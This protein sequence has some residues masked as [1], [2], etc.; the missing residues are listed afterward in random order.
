MKRIAVVLGVILALVLACSAFF[1]KELV[2]YFTPIK[3]VAEVATPILWKVSKAGVPDSWLLGTMHAADRRS[4]LLLP[5]FEPYLQQ[6]RIVFTEHKLFSAEDQ[7]FRDFLFS[8]KGGV[9][10]ALG[11]LYPQLLSKINKA[12]L[13]ANVIE[14]MDV[15][16]ALMA[17][18]MR[19]PAADV[20]A[21]SLDEQ[22]ASFALLHNKAYAGLE[23]MQDKITPL[24]EIPP[25]QQ[26]EALKLMITHSEQFDQ[27]YR[28]IVEGYYARSIPAKAI[29]HSYP[30]TIT[31]ELKIAL[32]KWDTA[33]LDKRNQIY[34]NSLA[35]HL[36]Q[37]ACFIAVGFKHLSGPQGLV[38][39]LRAQGY[40]L[41]PLY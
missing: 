25:A 32:Q 4:A 7:V 1:Y 29:D 27:S 11:D 2:F 14:S 15:P 5:R 33:M 21:T 3:P 31:P 9:R 40:S 22:I 30:A 26:L 16:Q 23:R 19:Q 20:G 24:T 6:A 17:L 34:L 39:L 12:Y 37:G 36:S 13:P 41:T 8:G 18:E 38:N 28:E 10:P 35:A